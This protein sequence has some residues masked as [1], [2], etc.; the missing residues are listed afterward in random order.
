MSPA[1][2]LDCSAAMSWFFSDERDAWSDALLDRVVRGGAVVPQLWLLEVA[3]VLAVA[4]R[5]AR[6][7]APDAVRAAELLRG[8]P[9]TVRSLGLEDIE[10]VLSL[11]RDCGLSAYD[12]TYLLTASR[13]GLPLASRDERLREAA[14]GRGVPTI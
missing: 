11:A 9:L 6:M 4:V 3:N 1:C 13:E 2:V 12:A 5:R 7:L 14:A 10:G 8:L